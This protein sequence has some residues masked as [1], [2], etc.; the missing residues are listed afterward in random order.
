[1][2]YEVQPI[3]ITSINSILLPSPLLGSI[4]VQDMQTEIVIRT[5][6]FPNSTQLPSIFSN[7]KIKRPDGTWAN[8]VRVAGVHLR[9]PDGTWQIFT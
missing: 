2:A 7:V 9:L 6:S 1:M 4:E 3:L 8:T 5:A